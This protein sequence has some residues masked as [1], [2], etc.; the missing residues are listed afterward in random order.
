MT[1]KSSKWNA[2]GS[3]PFAAGQAGSVRILT[4]GQSEK[5]VI[6]DAVK[7]A[8][9]EEVEEEQPDDLDENG[10]TDAWERRYFLQNGGVDPSA[11]PD[12]DGHTNLEECRLGSDPNDPGSPLFLSDFGASSTEVS[13]SWSG[14]AGRTYRVY[15]SEKLDPPAFEPFGDAIL[16]V[17]GEML[18]ELPRGTSPSAFFRIRDESAID[19]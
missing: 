4:I 3:W 14:I 10:L 19:W 13:I 15:R 2:I 17:D 7:F 16:G 8:V 1:V 12:G 18:V 9:V 11:D 6:A 5:T